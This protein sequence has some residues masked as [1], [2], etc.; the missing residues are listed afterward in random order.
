MQCI[1]FFIVF[2][3]LTCIDVNCILY[4][5][6]FLC[7]DHRFIPAFFMLK[8]LIGF[9]SLNKAFIIIIKVQVSVSVCG[10]SVDSDN[11]CSI[12]PGYQGVQKGNLAIVLSFNGLRYLRVNCIESVMELTYRVFL[13]Y[14]KTVVYVT[15]PDFW[16]CCRGGDCQFF[17]YFHAK[18]SYDGANW[19]PHCTSMYLFVDRVIKHEVVVREGEFQEGDDFVCVELRS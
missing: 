11:N 7:T 3:I 18:I 13:D 16:R 17:S 6:V 8:S 12:L 4:Q 14:D 5:V 15:F 9:F 2:L 19:A 1:S 10:L